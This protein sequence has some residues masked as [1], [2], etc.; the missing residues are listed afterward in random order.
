MRQGA[1]LGARDIVGTKHDY[2]CLSH[3]N[4]EF[5]MMNY[6]RAVSLLRLQG[7]YIAVICPYDL[8]LQKLYAFI[9]V[10]HLVFTYE[11]QE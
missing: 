3:N 5:Q 2:G 10:G 7:L 4:Y 1:M 11:E 9:Y 6:V 8:L